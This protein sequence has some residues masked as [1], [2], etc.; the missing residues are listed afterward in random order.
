MQAARYQASMPE[1]VHSSHI[2]FSRP[3]VILLL[4]SCFEKGSGER[5]VQSTLRES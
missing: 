2:S 5:N 3:A 4:Q 1:T